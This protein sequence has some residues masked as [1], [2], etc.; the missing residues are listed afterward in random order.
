[1]LRLNYPLDWEHSI[2]VKLQFLQYFL[3][4]YP[5]SQEFVGWPVCWDAQFSQSRCGLLTI[6]VDSSVAL[7]FRYTEK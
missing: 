2:A 3:F 5:I 4:C 1:M 7:S 6:S